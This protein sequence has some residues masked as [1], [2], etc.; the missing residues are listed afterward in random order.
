[1]TFMVTAPVLAQTLR[2]YDYA[3]PLRNERQLRAVVE[4]AAG[5]LMVRP[6]P[7][8]RLYGM[9]LK[10]DAE[11]FQPVGSYN[12]GTA[13]VRLGVAN[14]G[15]G[16]LR[17]NRERALP[18]VAVVEFP[19]GV[20]LTLDVTVGAAEGTLELG[21][22]RISD[23]DL[24]SGASRTTISF[25]KPN[26][27]SC[28]TAQL[29]SGAGELTI[30]SAGNSG[31]RSWRFDGGVGAV[32]VDLDGAW[33]ADSRMVMNLAL[34]GVKLQ[35]P[36]DLGLRVRVTGFMSGFDAKGF[37]K[38]GKTYTSSN[39]ASAKRHIEVEVTSALGGVDVVWK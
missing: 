1:M 31:C 25:D 33:P 3:R 24:K 18:Q 11:R 6:G 2:D 21:G 17:V 37:T 10:Y 4:F 23:L 32:T 9:V 14:H 26:P 7:A 5:R 19:G 38:D 39:Y 12:A 29:T 28:R 16:G 22:L 34:G 8:D 15:G 35:A 30:S 36:R 13:E 27:G 20:D